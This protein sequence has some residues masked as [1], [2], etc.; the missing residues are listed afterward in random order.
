MKK[1]NT[2]S[3]P[4]EKHIMIN[5]NI[6]KI[7]LRTLKKM[8]DKELKYFTNDNI[9]SSELG[10]NRKANFFVF[11]TQPSKNDKK[12]LSAKN[13][14][15]IIHGNRTSIK[16]ENVFIFHKKMYINFVLYNIYIHIIPNS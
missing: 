2:I 1:S 9:M 12:R 6:T 10:R 15:Q 11:K 13:A 8:D 3:K 5:K 16:I 14:Y 4:K 7:P